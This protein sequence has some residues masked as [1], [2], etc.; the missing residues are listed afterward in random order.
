MMD[1]LLWFALYFAGLLLTF[2]GIAALCG[3]G[4]GIMWLASKLPGRVGSYLQ[5]DQRRE[6]GAAIVFLVIVLGFMLSL[7]LRLFERTPLEK[8][9]PLSANARIFVSKCD[10]AAV[11]SCDY[12][13]VV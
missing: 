12:P 8:T 7:W 5:D 9:Q 2:L 3:V 6:V 11:E 10:A 1:A 4:Y 13:C